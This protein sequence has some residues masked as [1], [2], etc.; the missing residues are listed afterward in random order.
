L[1][2]KGFKMETLL[3][4]L[5]ETYHYCCEGEYKERIKERIKLIREAMQASSSKGV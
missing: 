3:M 1:I 5:L 4:E 2:S